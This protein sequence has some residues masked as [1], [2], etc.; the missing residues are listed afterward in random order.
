M[1]VE[2]KSIAV[3][4]DQN[5][6]GYWCFPTYLRHLAYSNQGMVS[7]WIPSVVVSI[8][9][10]LFLFQPF[11]IFFQSSLMNEIAFRA[12]EFETKSFI[13]RN[14]S[15]RKQSQGEVVDEPENQDKMKVSE[16]EREEEEIYV[17]FFQASEN[18][19][20]LSEPMEDQVEIS[21]NESA[22][23]H[24]DIPQSN[25]QIYNSY[26]PTKEDLEIV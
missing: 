15:N 21:Q 8:V 19:G 25:Q 7:N 17:D 23:Q 1:D 13:S 26:T 4:K 2:S 16:E 14:P 10:D 5:H 22:A 12:G 20:D 3:H 6:F 18:E 9:T 24:S 11:L